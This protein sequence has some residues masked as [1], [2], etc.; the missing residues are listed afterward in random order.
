MAIDLGRL[1]FLNSMERKEPVLSYITA[2]EK[3]IHKIIGS[4]TFEK[5]DFISIS[6]L[7]SS[8]KST[9]QIWPENSDE[10]ELRFRVV[11]INAHV[12]PSLKK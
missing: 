5:P 4:I 1:R 7:I 2:N 12:E 9:W 11:R 8:F 6:N 3:L 10:I